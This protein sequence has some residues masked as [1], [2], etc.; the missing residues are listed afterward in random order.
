MY[1]NVMRSC[2][3]SARVVGKIYDIMETEKEI[4]APARWIS[5]CFELE[6]E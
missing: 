6:Q 5:A 4:R 3:K 1:K 2:M